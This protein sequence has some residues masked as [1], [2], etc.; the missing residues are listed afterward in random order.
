[1]FTFQALS[2]PPRHLYSSVSSSILIRTCWWMQIFILKF[3]TICTNAV[4]QPHWIAHKTFFPKASYSHHIVPW[5]PCPR[6]AHMATFFPSSVPC[7]LASDS[8][9]APPW[10]WQL[11][12]IPALLKVWPTDHCQAINHLLPV[13]DVMSSE[14]KCFKTFIVIQQNIYTPFESNNKKCTKY[15]MVSWIG[16]WNEKRTL[17][18]KLLKSKGSPWFS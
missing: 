11:F 7:A 5:R 18:E 10:T 8:P 3:S 16:S 9:A 4:S 13:H 17:A 1:M 14:I 12:F 6:P 2:S 15:N